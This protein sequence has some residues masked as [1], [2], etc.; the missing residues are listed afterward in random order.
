MA[1]LVDANVL[2]EATKPRPNEE[3]VAWLKANESEFFVDPVIL[4]ELE[5]GILL[6]PRGRK[7]ADLEHWFRALSDRIECLKWD[8]VVSRR[9]ARLVVELRRKGQSLPILDGM[10]AA[11]ALVHHL[12]LATHNTRDFKKAGVRVFDPFV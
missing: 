9:W 11:T 6:L 8:A 2:S 3:V 10:I 1:Y 7:R 4:G 5:V 12:T